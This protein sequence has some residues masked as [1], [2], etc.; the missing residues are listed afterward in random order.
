MRRSKLN[1]VLTVVSKSEWRY[2]DRPIIQVG[3]PYLFI[4]DEPVFMS[5]IAPFL[6]YQD[7]NLLPGTIFGGRFPIDVWPRPLMWAFEWHNSEKAIRLKRGQH[8][9]TVSLSF[10][11][12]SE[13]SKFSKLNARRN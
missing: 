5:Q 2:P 6:H 1:K 9:F 7:K 10:I 8:S 12:R 11:M 13:V 3:L 4:A